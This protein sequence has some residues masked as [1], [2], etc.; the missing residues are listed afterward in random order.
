M[1]MAWTFGVEPLPQTEVAAGLLRRVSGLVVAM[2]RSEPAVDR[3]IARLQE[4]ERDL[5]AVAPVDPHPRVGPHVGSEGRIYLD[6]SRHI[7]L[8]NPCFPEY[9]IT[10]EGDRA[11]GTVSF[12]AVYEGPPGIVHGGFIAVLVDCVVQHHNCDLG[13]AGKTSSLAV[14]FRRPAP[15]VT[16]LRFEVDRRADDR[17]ITSA[18]HLLAHGV[19][20]AEAE[21]RAV[22]GE[23]ANLPEV[24][25]RR[26]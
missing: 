24:S 8:H 5:A 7:G 21:V 19:E 22:A 6:H 13:V 4:A 12:P 10:V 16:P 11:W 18:V 1:E 23:R 25:G 3:L 14:R 15:L 17:R 26:A 2:E 9:V 20:C